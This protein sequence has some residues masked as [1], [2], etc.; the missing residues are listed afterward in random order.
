MKNPLILLFTLYVLTGY[1]QEKQRINLVFGGDIMVHDDQLKSGWY[2][3]DSAWNFR[4]WFDEIDH[5]FKAADLCIANLEVP[6]GVQP[7]RGYPSFG[8]PAAL[9]SDLQDVGFNVLM[10][11]NNHASDRGKAGIISTRE[12]L[13]SLEI[14][15]TGVWKSK[16][17]RED[18]TPLII[19]KKGFR[20]AF[21]NYTYG[22]NAAPF[23]DLI[24][25]R[26]EN[27]IKQDIEFA[28]SKN[29]DKIFVF[30]HWGRESKSFPSESQKKL[31]EMM[32]EW[33]ADYIIGAH[34]HVIQ[35]IEWTKEDENERFIAWS[36]GNVISNMY[37][38][39]TDGGALLQMQLEKEGEDVKIASASYLLMYVY[40][41]LDENE[42]I[43]YRLL[44]MHEYIEQ[45]YFFKAD[46][47]EKML[48]YKSLV[49]P[50]MEHNINVPVWP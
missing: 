37:Y 11:A 34:P 30:M 28:K 10:T 3:E 6:L 9:A 38:K 18:L 23:L 43:Q 39:R 36:L 32:F 16:A 19:E 2:D 20:L 49:D 5:L 50:V 22:T 48:K 33:G 8:A 40:K 25:H 15:N 42:H 46:S 45:Q 24:S 31:A 35:P 7:F 1:A 29:P 27:E 17:Q 13:D 41:Y 47:Y 44:P 21:L 4:V 14:L 26:I 12:I